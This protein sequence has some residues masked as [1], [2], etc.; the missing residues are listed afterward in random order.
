MGMSAFYGSA[1]DGEA[2]ATILH[3]PELGINF[4]DTA[5]MYGPMTN[6]ELVG[7]AIKGR[8]DEYVITTKFA[9]RMDGASPGDPVGDCL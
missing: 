2:I 1:D 9:W 3:A 6:E 4:L 8:R 5:Q 7:R